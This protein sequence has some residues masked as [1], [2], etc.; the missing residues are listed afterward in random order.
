MSLTFVETTSTVKT[1]G[2][3][4]HYNEAG[5]VEVPVVESM[6]RLTE[7]MTF[8]NARFATDELAAERSAN[9][10]AHPEHLANYLDGLTRGGPVAGGSTAAGTG[11]RS[12][13]PRSSTASSP[14]SSP[15]TD[16]TPACRGLGSSPGLRE[17]NHQ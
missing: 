13:M 9:A 7:V 1:I 16:H 10:M 3:I 4:S 12:S 11:P 15:T 6:K 14:S 8:D 5:P 17:R 2:C